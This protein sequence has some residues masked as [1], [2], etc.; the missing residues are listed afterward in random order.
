MNRALRAEVSRLPGDRV[1]MVCV[2]AAVILRLAAGSA[3][4]GAGAA[5]VNVV[6]A[7]SVASLL[8]GA[9][10]TLQVRRGIV[11]SAL[12]Q[13]R[14]TEVLAAQFAAAALGGVV[15]GLVVAICAALTG[16]HENARE[17]IEGGFACAIAGFLGAL[18][19]AA[20][21]VLVRNHLMTLF[22]VPLAVWAP[23]VC[24][25]S[26]P[27][28]LPWSLVGAVT[29]LTVEPAAWL[30]LV[31]AAAWVV[32]GVLVSWVVFEVRNQ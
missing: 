16:T 28:S 3:A 2:G 22:V 29:G 14:R 8:G 26:I 27:G 10:F 11:E 32:V 9:R 30:L 6:V 17:A 13:S 5:L 31:V 21:G 1:L 4:D 15:V 23:W 19:G 25:V 18:W 7:V 20:V 24:E 12:M